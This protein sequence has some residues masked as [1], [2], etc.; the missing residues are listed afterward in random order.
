VLEESELLEPL[1][2]S[3][4][5]NAEEKKSVNKNK[6]KQSL[7]EKES[8]R[9][10]TKLMCDSC[11]KS[12]STRQSLQRHISNVHKGLKSFSCT[13][14]DSKFANSQGLKHHIAAVHE[15][16]KP[17]KCQTCDSSF[18]SNQQ[19]KRHISAVHEGQK[20]FK[21]QSCEYTCALKYNLDLHVNAVHCNDTIN[22]SKCNEE[23]TR[24]DLKKKHEG[25]CKGI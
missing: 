17:F 11:K 5:G 14:C 3:K 8:K 9:Q 4:Q 13:L 24:K 18:A 25:N 21:C 22:C 1:K 23:F 12:Y 2:C 6:R 20:P 19:L 15:G 10:C 16:K 7:Q